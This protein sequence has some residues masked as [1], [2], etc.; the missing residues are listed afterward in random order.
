ME[1]SSLNDCIHHITH[2]TDGHNIGDKYYE[3]T[4]GFFF[5]KGNVFSDTT[6]QILY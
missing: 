2:L 5:L 4:V 1:H 6:V 3:S